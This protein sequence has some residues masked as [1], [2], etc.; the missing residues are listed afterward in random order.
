MDEYFLLRILS[1]QR[2]E[3]GKNFVF[4]KRTVP[5]HRY[6]FHPSLHHYVALMLSG[7][8]H[9]YYDTDAHPCKRVKSFRCGLPSTIQ[10]CIHLKELR[11]APERQLASKEML[12]VS[13]RTNNCSMMPIGGEVPSRRK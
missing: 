13:G 9:V 1:E 12:R 2:K 11:H 8:S 4:R 5:R 7:T 6:V 10:L 3:A